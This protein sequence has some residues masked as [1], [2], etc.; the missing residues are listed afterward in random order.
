MPFLVTRCGVLETPGIV[1]AE[2][3]RCSFPIR[4][5][6]CGKAIVHVKRDLSECEV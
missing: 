2:L 4:A 5:L 1:P 6:L 3:D